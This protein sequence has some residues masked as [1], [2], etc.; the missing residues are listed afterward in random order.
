MK[1]YEVI[2][3]IITPVIIHNGES[4]D[5]IE[6]MVPNQNTI[7][8][9]AAD[10]AFSLM[11]EKEREKY[12]NSVNML[13]GNI[14]HDKEKLRTIS[15]INSTIHGIV[16]KNPEII[17]AKAKTNKRFLDDLGKNPHATVCKI[18]KDELTLAPYIPGSSVKGAIRTAILEM[19]RANQKRER[20]KRRFQPPDFEMQI[21]KNSNDAFFE[22]TSDPFRFLKISDFICQN[23]DICFDTV[24]VV[25]KDRKEKGIPIYTEMTASWKT[26]ECNCIAKGIISIDQEGLASFCRAKGIKINISKESILQS[27]NNFGTMLLE[28]K[29]HPIENQL[30]DHIKKHSKEKD[31]A[32]LRLGRFAQI[33]SKTFKIKRDDIKP[34]DI[35]ISGGSSRSFIGGS[36]PA[37]WCIIEMRDA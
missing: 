31:C 30:K 19:E 16:L 10:K 33:E 21:M 5:I 22:I 7:W 3:H 23:N 32:P 15:T 34:N 17:K 28:N 24:R 12:F 4:Y 25:G 35:N 26:H 14:D 18:F 37:G 13:S 6:M 2:L 27:L 9:I 29:K 11:S 20:P 8:V 36:I 1:H